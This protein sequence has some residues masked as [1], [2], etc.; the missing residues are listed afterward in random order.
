II[1]GNTVSMTTFSPVTGGT[2]PFGLRD[3]VTLTVPFAAP[4][5]ELTIKQFGAFSKDGTLNAEV[6]GYSMKNA[7]GEEYTE[8]TV[9]TLAAGDQLEPIAPVYTDRAQLQAL[10]DTCKVIKKGDYTTESY[11]AMK[12][13]IK[14]AK[15]A[16]K[17]G[18]DEDVAT[19]FQAL[20]NAK[21]ALCEEAKGLTRD[22][23]ELVHEFDL[24]L[25]AWENGDGTKKLT[26]PHS[27]VKAEQLEDGGFTAEK[28][29]MAANN[30]PA[31]V[32]KEPIT[33]TPKDGKLYIALDVE[34]GSTWSVYPMIIQDKQ[35]YSG[36]WNYVI[37]GSH[38]TT[39]DAGS[40]PYKGVFDV[41]EALEA[42][43]IDMT[44][45][46]TISF[47]MNVVPG[48]VTVREMA[49]L[50]G[51]PSGFPWLWIAVVAAALLVVGGLVFAILYKPKKTEP[52]TTPEDVNAT[53]T[54]AIE[55]QEA[56]DNEPTAET[57]EDN[58]TAET[59]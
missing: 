8:Y 59:E 12:A 51:E 20:T 46:M 32:Y 9:I 41:T 29:A 52:A 22:S 39:L 16:V 30:W 2:S 14:A 27:H 36:R 45:E 34:A 31:I 37:E 28:G 53:D 43:G 38:K 25:G 24:D 47:S 40:G 7:D 49:L 48:P 17:N 58:D 19:A 54:A 5:R 13:A 18:T 42:M 21:G 11:N 33:F 1:D 35:Q 10:I 26:T 55:V 23:L 15:A 6:H 56:A 4:K 57:P 44:E 3:T 50:T